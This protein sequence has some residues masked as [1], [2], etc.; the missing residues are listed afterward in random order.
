MDAMDDTGSTADTT[1]TAPGGL[2]WE[3][4][5]QQDQAPWDIGRPQ[6]V[7]VRLADA[8]EITS[9]VLDSGCGTGEHTLLLASR[10]MDVLG[11]DVSRTAIDRARQKAADRGLDADFQVGDVLALHHLGRTFATIID[12]GVFHVFSDADRVRYVDSLASVL[13][14]G[15]VLHLLAFSELTPGERG[16]RRVTQAELRAAFADG[17]EVERI[18]AAELE[19]RPDWSED[20][21]PLLAGAHRPH[22]LPCRRGPPRRDHRGAAIPFGRRAAGGGLPGR[23]RAHDR[24]PPARRAA[25]RGGLP[26]IRGPPPRDILWTGWMSR[27]TGRNRRIG[28]AP[29]CRIAQVRLLP[30]GGDHMRR[31]VPLILG[32]ILL[33][34]V[35]A[36][37]LRGRHVRASRDPHLAV[38]DAQ[39]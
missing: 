13:Q 27:S 20:R 39:P 1:G 8:G 18:E 32:P 19:V 7:W 3:E 9:P 16:P 11:L 33:L 35:R 5:Y 29:A 24:E 28:Q 4:V 21:S 15:G 26:A 37:C 10:G 25:D 6:A 12:S 22:R 30:K 36:A 14:Q 31:A 17:W 23:H 34:V 38:G 2:G